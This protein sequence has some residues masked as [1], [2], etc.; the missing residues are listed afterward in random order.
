L[1]TSKNTLASFVT[2]TSIPLPIRS[3]EILIALEERFGCLALCE[4]ISHV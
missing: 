4:Q 2:S 3:S 1:S